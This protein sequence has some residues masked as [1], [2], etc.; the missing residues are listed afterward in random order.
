MKKQ[1][2]IIL[3]FVTYSTFSQDY[4]FISKDYTKID[5]Y[6]Y[7]DILQKYPKSPLNRYLANGKEV[8][9]AFSDSIGNPKFPDRYQHLY[10][11][12]T[13][14]HKTILVLRKMSAEEIKSANKKST[15]SINKDLKNRKELRGSS[16]DKLNLTDI[17]GNKYS[18]ESL[19]G[20]IIVLNFWFTKCAPCIKEMP[21]LNKMKAKYQ[22][23]DVVFF[24]VTNDKKDI[25][26]RFLER[27]KLDFT[28]IPNDQAT[29]DQFKISYFPTNVLI[30]K[31]G[32]IEFV[33]EMFKGNGIEE[34]NKKLKQLL[35]K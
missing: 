28:I 26:N 13:I 34:I 18:L 24:A 17:D 4:P 25:V 12:D 23:D 5:S 20:K 33:N 15:E 19:K 35:K 11:A 6:Q 27:I 29:I 14:N 21:D 16:I 1:L 31:E 30:N 10:F 32:K 2:L 9:K 22:S 3:L 8:T 7:I